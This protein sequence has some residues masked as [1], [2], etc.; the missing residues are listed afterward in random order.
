[1]G[2]RQKLILILYAFAIFILGFVYVPY[3]QYFSNGVKIHKGHHIRPTMLWTTK[4]STHQSV[5]IDASLII[6]EIIA[7]TAISAALFLLSKRE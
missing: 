1:M 3:T 5:D 7:L 2:K 4:I 6:A